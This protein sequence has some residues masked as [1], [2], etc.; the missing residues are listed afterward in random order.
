M[1]I[2]ALTSGRRVPSARFRVRQYV[3]YLASQGIQVTEYIPVIEKYATIPGWPI[4]VSQKYVFPL[5]ILWQ[6]IKLGTRIPGIIGSHTHAAT[7]LEREMLPGYFGLEGLLKSPLI[8]DVDD[9]IWLT[10]PFG[11]RTV[12]RI[13]RRAT[14]IFAGNKFLANWLSAYNAKIAI[15]PTAIDT[16][17]YRPSTT[18]KQERSFFTV[19]WTGLGS[20]LVYLEAV[21]SALRRFF[22]RYPDVRLSIVADTRPRFNSIID[23]RILFTQ[24]SPQNEAAAV[25]EMDVGLMP[26]PDNDWTRGKCS[27]KMLQYMAT[28]IPV[29]V[30]PVGMNAEI[31]DMQPVGLPA[32]TNDDWLDA[33]IFLYENRSQAAQYGQLGRQ[34]ALER[35]STEVVSQQIAKQFRELV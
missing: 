26:L 14:V 1:R 11:S 29:I 35:Y 34:L 30:S 25:R 27:F 21:E 2:A 4:N 23:D 9:A 6:S 20:N 33:L 31:L 28:G 18:S 17:R 24:W 12:S 16:R 3:P 7:W 32:I 10:R 13:A 5:F 15:V 8:F 19:G 22:D